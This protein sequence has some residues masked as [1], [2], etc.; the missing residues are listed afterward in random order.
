[1][2][3]R[4]RGVRRQLVPLK[5]RNTRPER[6]FGDLRDSSSFYIIVAVVV[7]VIAG[8]YCKAEVQ[9]RLIVDSGRQHFPWN[10]AGAWCLQENSCFC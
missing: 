2:Y 10:A 9:H 6:C 4:M 3:L 1:M 5:D 8:F 7:I